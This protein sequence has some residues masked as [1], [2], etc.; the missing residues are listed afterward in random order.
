VSYNLWIQYFS[1][2][3]NTKYV[4]YYIII[5]IRQNVLHFFCVFIFTFDTICALFPLTV[6]SHLL[7]RICPP[8]YM[9]T[10]F[11]FLRVYH[12]FYNVLPVTLVLMVHKPK[13]NGVATWF[14]F[15]IFITIAFNGPHFSFKCK[16]GMWVNYLLNT[17][18]FNCSNKFK[19]VKVLLYS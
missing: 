18:I 12:I 16:H 17:S 19:A 13:L 9:F 10:Y 8:T 3:I 14:F 15:H 5:R 2:N 1:P 4:I 11:S 7:H 6:I